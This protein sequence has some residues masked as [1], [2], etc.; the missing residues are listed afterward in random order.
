MK[1]IEDNGSVIEFEDFGE[2]RPIF[3]VHGSFSGAA[4]WRPVCEHLPPKFRVLAPNLWAC[5]GTSDWPSDGPPTISLQ[6]RLVEKVIDTVRQPVHLVAHSHGGVVA[7]ATALSR[8]HTV[9]SLVLLDPLPANVLQLAGE[10]EAHDAL[11]H[12]HADYVEAFEAGVEEAGA[13]VVDY[14][15]GQGTFAA[16]PERFRAHIAATTELNIKDWAANW[17]FQPEREE[18]GRLEIPTLLVWGASG[19]PIAGAIGRSLERLLGAA[20]LTTLEGASH[21]MIATHAK[22]IA[23]L[24][25]K[26]AE[27]HSEKK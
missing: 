4:A 18:L 25:S 14:W 10:N 1:S 19:N 5:G 3:F 2:G 20:R 13:R 15:T 9:R 17:A 7:L 6:A 12:F 23:E 21:L 22:T 8:P 27:A 11:R 24:V 16:L 26:H